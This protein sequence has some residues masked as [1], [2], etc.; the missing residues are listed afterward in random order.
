MWP[1]TSP[2]L[3]QLIFSLKVVDFGGMFG[4]E[5]FEHTFWLLD[6]RVGE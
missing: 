6:F 1:L 5:H 2:V 4:V 3:D